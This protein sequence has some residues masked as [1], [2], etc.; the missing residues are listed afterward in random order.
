VI[1]I[2]RDRG[3]GWE[4]ALRAPE[5]TPEESREVWVCLLVIIMLR[6]VNGSQG[7]ETADSTDLERPAASAHL[8]SYAGANRIRFNGYYLSLGKTAG[9]PSR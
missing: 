2:L 8:D 6:C 1:Y 5:E 9:T 3:K 4:A 7:T